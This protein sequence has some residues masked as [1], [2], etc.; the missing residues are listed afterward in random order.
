MPLSKL[1][2]LQRRVEGQASISGPVAIPL[3]RLPRAVGGASLV[4]WHM[5][6]IRTKRSITIGKAR[7]RDAAVVE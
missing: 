4:V 2:G 7:L 1:A 6:I 5:G 3:L